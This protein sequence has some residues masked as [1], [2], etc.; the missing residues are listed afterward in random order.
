MLYNTRTKV[1]QNTSPQLDIRLRR[2]RLIPPNAKNCYQAEEQRSICLLVFHKN[3]KFVVLLDFTQPMDH[4]YVGSIP[5][6]PQS[7]Y[8]LLTQPIR[9]YNTSLNEVWVTH[10][11]SSGQWLLNKPQNMKQFAKK[12]QTARMA[13]YFVVVEVFQRGKP[14]YAMAAYYTICTL[15][16]QIQ[17]T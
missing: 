2:N 11:N 10:Y 8:R 1:Q 6:Y 16:K 15:S 14:F 7:L 5:I 4:Q 9:Y 13:E 3:N 12:L 17:H